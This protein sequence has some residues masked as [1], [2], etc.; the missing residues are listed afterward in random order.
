MDRI[1]TAINNLIINENEAIKSRIE[2]VRYCI[3]IPETNSKGYCYCLKVDANGRLRLQDLIE[4]I[5]F[6]IVDYAIPKKEIDEAKNDLNNTGSTRKIIQLRK[7]AENLFTDLDKTGEGGEILLYILTQDILKLP[8]LISK[9]SLKTSAKMHYQG[10]DG[11]HFRYNRTTGNLE[12]YWAEAKMY[13]NLN[14]ALTNC[15]D[16]LKGFLLDPKGCASTQERDIDLITSNIHQNINDETVEDILVE[17][18]DK[19]KEQSNH[20]VYKGVC[21]I[22]FDYDK[23]PSDTDITKTTEHIKNAI[24]TEYEKWHST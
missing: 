15:F 9:M 2:E 21:F 18:F 20:L 10:A 3:D 19:D 17:Y 6:R 8:Q 11:V 23:Y 7:K 14:A 22:G 4:Y 1:E 16:S 12:L 5:D 24:L 13:Q